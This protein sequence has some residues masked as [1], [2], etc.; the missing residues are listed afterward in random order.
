MVREWFERFDFFI[1][2]QNLRVVVAEDAAAPVIEQARVKNL[3]NFI[4]KVD[5]TV[6][7]L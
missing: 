3:A 6:V 7:P 1:I 5:G 2:A 4:S